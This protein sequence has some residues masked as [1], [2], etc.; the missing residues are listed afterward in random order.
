LD[1]LDN[2]SSHLD[3]SHFAFCYDERMRNLVRPLVFL[4]LLLILAAALLAQSGTGSLALSAHVAPTGAAAEPVRQFTFYV[5]TKSYDD[6]LKEVEQQDALPTR[7]QFIEKWPCSP[8]LKKWLKEHDTINLSSPDIEQM[9]TTDDIMKIPEF[10]DAYER[11]NSGG[12]AKGLPQPKYKDSDKQNNP[13]RYQKL[14][15][16][17]L[18]ETRRYIDANPATIQGIELKLDTVDPQPSWNKIHSDH[19]RKVARLAPDTAQLK[20]LA[21]KAETDLDG[22]AS[23]NGLPAGTYWVSSLGLDA[24]SGDRH[25][26]WD[27]QAKVLAGQTTRLE[28]SNLNASDLK[29]YSAP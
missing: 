6:I 4:G 16:E 18:A 5:L 19:R 17:Y 15:D 23:V 25:V 12:V 10:F 26:I 7:D 22:R 27:V 11:F 29:P 13:A 24:S 9:L 3:S 20:Y 2:A 14:H 1:P 21:G 28:L 8:E